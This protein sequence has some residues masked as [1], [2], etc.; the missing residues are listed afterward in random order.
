MIY[1]ILSLSIILLALLYNYLKY[2]NAKAELEKVKNHFI[3][4]CQKN[5]DGNIAQYNKLSENQKQFLDNLSMYI[6]CNNLLHLLNK[7]MYDIFCLDMKKVNRSNQLNKLSYKFKD[8]YCV[9]DIYDVLYFVDKQ[10]HE[11]IKNHKDLNFELLNINLFGKEHIGDDELLN[12]VLNMT[13]KD[14]VITFSS[15]QS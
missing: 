14:F 13:L 4:N 11:Y 9:K 2:S 10:Y 8:Y 15:L 6:G 12:M 5:F 1:F 3:I 7:K